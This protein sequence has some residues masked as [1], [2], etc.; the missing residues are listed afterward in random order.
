MGDGGSG[1][2]RFGAR[3]E[4]H[5]TGIQHSGSGDFNA[6]N[7]YIG[8]PPPYASSNCEPSLQ[9]TYLV[10][11]GLD[12]CERNLN[13]LL[14]LIVQVSS[15][16]SRAKLIVSSRNWPDI[17][18][19]MADAT[20]K[21]RLCLELNAESISAAV[22]DYIQYKVDQLMRSKKYDS[23]T[24][25]AV[26]QHLTSNANDTF[27]WVALVCQELADPK[28]R[29]WHTRGKLLSF[30]PGLNALY[31]RMMDRVSNSDDADICR[32]VL[33]L[34]S[35]AHRPLSLVE[36]S[37]L[38]GLLEDYVDDAVSLEEIV[39]TCG[40]LLTLRDGVVY[41][42][43][44]S[45]KDFLL[46]DEAGMYPDG[47]AREHRFPIEQGKPPN[48]DPLAPARY[49]C[50]YW[51]YHLADGA[52]SGQEQDSG[53]IYAFLRQHYLHWLEAL[54]LLDSISEGILQMSKLTYL[55]KRT[56]LFRCM[57]PHSFFTP[58]RSV[59]RELFRHEEPKW[60]AVKPD[61][62]DEWNSCLQTFE[63]HRGGVT[64]VA[65]SGDGT[66][67]ASA[68]YDRTIK[69]WDLTTGQCLQTFKGHTGIVT[70][71]AW[72]EDTTAKVWD[73]TGRCL[74][75]LECHSEHT[76]FLVFSV[77]GT[78]LASASRNRTVK[79]WDTTGRCLQTLISSRDPLL[80]SVSI[81]RDAIVI[82]RAVLFLLTPPSIASW[83]GFVVIIANLHGLKGLAPIAYNE[84]HGLNDFRVCEKGNL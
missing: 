27:L 66:Q 62:E 32:E 52:P 80:V 60:L 68:S 64:S 21:I 65:V 39:S 75:T 8:R 30:P 16:S 84:S 82:Q 83:P 40:S 56:I 77:D 49:S 76:T 4:L 33:R 55:T 45:A 35:I 70:S 36:L 13:Q 3:S 20:Q 58:M 81:C 31:A 61:M 12:E 24:R 6:H 41:F 46:K 28:V 15:S 48:P 63:G 37:S 67:L 71:V 25:D 54:S 22:D 78:R 17:E 79:V 42:V 7:I 14:H 44:Q 50:V 43:H 53:L 72:S 69:I 5:G 29:R 57:L 47:V 74:Q 9:R 18:D 11:D 19:A 2:S 38:A 73:T 34:V 10:I 59:V 23:E 26:Q 1:S 51:V